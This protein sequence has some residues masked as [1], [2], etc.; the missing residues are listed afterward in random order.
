MLW[1]KAVFSDNLKAGKK[2]VSLVV[3]DQPG[4]YNKTLTQNKTK[5]K[6]AM[7]LG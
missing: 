4:K 5:Q 7:M 3:Q 6:E 2:S 1:Y